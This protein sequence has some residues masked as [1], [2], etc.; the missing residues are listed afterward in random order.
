MLRTSTLYPLCVSLLAL[1]T[2]LSAQ[3]A[4]AE[5]VGTVTDSSGAGIPKAKVTVTNVIHESGDPRDRIRFL[6]ALTLPP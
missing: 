5:L 3:T 2:D 1:T 4:T 6:R